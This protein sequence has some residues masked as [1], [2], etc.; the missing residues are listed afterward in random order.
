MQVNKNTGLFILSLTRYFQW[1][2]AK[3]EKFFRIAVYG[4]FNFYKEISESML[5]KNVGLLNIEVSQ[6]NR[7]EEISI[8]KPQIIVISSEKCCINNISLAKKMLQNTSTMIICTK[9]GSLNQGADIELI[10]ENE[11]LNFNYNKESI[12]N[13]GIKI[14]KHL[15][16]FMK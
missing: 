5:G 1:P 3:E 16:V 2:T 8:I 15:D 7:L 11:K 4:D 13:K 14:S 6:L 12:T 9:K 10:I